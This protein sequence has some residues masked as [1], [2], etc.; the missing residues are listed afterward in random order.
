MHF[1]F[2]IVYERNIYSSVIEQAEITRVKQKAIEG[3]KVN[4]K[5]RKI[6]QLFSPPPVPYMCVNACV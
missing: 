3:K 2:L 5:K 4:K 6:L 1:A